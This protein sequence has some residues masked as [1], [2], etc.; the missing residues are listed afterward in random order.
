MNA[1]TLGVVDFL[2]DPTVGMS[3][4]ADETDEQIL[5]QPPPTA[6]E[7]FHGVHGLGFTNDA[8]ETLDELYRFIVVVTV[9]SGFS[10]VDRDNVA[11]L[12]DLRTRAEQIRA[13]IHSSYDLMQL[14]NTRVGT[15]ANGFVEPPR[16]ESAT[17][18]EVRGPEWFWGEGTEDPPTGISITLTFGRARRVQ[19]IEEQ[20]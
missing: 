3:L 18:P 4:S 2:R 8:T 1:L 11:V 7:W 19:R 9:R 14:V 16:F 13:K 6:G 10:P 15:S 17:P 20:A 12:R 5:G